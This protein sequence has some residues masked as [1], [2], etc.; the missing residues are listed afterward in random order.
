[1]KMGKEFVKN[2]YMQ[3]IEACDSN[4]ENQIRKSFFN[5]L[6]RVSKCLLFTDES[7]SLSNMLQCFSWSFRARDFA[8]IEKLDIFEK[9]YQGFNIV[10]RTGEE[11]EK[12]E[13]TINL[14]ADLRTTQP[15]GKLIKICNNII[16]NLYLSLMARLS[17]PDSAVV[18]IDKKAEVSENVNPL[19]RALSSVNVN[20]AESLLGQALQAFFKELQDFVQVS[21]RYQ[22]HIT[23]EHVNLFTS[24]KNGNEMPKFKDFT[25][26]EEEK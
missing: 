1:M 21:P 14:I 19:S 8:S 7:E 4:L 13:E 24:W 5:I 22:E 12:K 11:E 23:S 20:S 15:M 26:E 6:Q 3:G 16:D 25:S 2:H 17:E 18:M 10:K 9:L